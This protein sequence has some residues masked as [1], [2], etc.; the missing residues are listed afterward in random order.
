M[1]ELET[2]WA[3]AKYLMVNTTITILVG[4]MMGWTMLCWTFGAL[5][6]QKKHADTRFLVYLS[7]VLWYVLLIAHPIIIFCSWKA[8]L[9]FSEALF[10]LL[11]C[12][13]LFGVI[14]AR[15]VGTE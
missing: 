10:P 12:H 14:F 9:T 4:A 7:K 2:G 13:V 15:D 11:I 5:N 3:F 6:F 8:W 1:G